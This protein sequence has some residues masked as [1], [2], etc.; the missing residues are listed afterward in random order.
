[1]IGVPGTGGVAGR[2]YVQYAAPVPFVDM[3]LRPR[4][5]DIRHRPVVI[6]YRRSL[7]Q[8]VTLLVE[9]ALVVALI[10][11]PRDHPYLSGLERHLLLPCS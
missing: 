6:H 9:Y 1:M 4:G 3:E 7:Q 5:S 10:G 2:P 11:V 8:Q